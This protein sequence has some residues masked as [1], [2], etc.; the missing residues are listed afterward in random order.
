MKEKDEG[1]YDSITRSL[2]GKTNFSFSFELIPITGRFY[3]A[4]VEDMRD[5]VEKVV[6]TEE[7]AKEEGAKHPPKHGHHVSHNPGVIEHGEFK[8]K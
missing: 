5:D 3:A 1:K 7:E 6:V 8:K 4:G 2:K